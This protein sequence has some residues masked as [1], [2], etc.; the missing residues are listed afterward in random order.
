MPQSDQILQQSAGE[1]P[2]LLPVPPQHHDLTIKATHSGI[3]I[4]KEGRFKKRYTGSRTAEVDINGRLYLKR[5]EYKKM[6]AGTIKDDAK[7]RAPRSAKPSE[8]SN[9]LEVSVSNITENSNNSPAREYRVNKVEVKN[10]IQGMINTRRGKRELYFWTIT[11]PAGI[12]DDL[13]YQAFNTWLTALRQ[14]KFLRNYLWVA[15]RQKNGTVHFHMTVPHKMSV[16]LAN[17][18]MRTTLTGY[19]KKGLLGNYSVFQAKRYNGV[20]L[21]KNRKTGR[22][23]N[24]AIKKGMRALSFYLTKYVTKNDAGFPHLAWHNSRGFSALFTGVT[25]TVNEF[26]KV[27]FDKLLF[28][29][30]V[31]NNQF[32]MFFPWAKDPPDLLFDHLHDL[33]SYIGEAAAE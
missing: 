21:A 24:F 10:R 20:D 6:I 12:P 18:Y 14:K 11:F 2:R 32:F 3:V 22:V 19:C 15:E 30:S 5:A 28:R 16:V 29:R 31:L 23:T 33:N 7:K 17:R 4:L 13:A 1:L 8:L 25:F 9:P 26:L 27:G